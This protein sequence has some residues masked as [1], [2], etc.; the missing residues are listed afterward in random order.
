MTPTIRRETTSCENRTYIGLSIKV[1]WWEVPCMI[2]LFFPL[3]TTTVNRLA[4]SLHTFHYIH[5]SDNMKHLHIFLSS[6]H[7]LPYFDMMNE[8]LIMVPNTWHCGVWK[9]SGDDSYLLYPVILCNLCQFK[10]CQGLGAISLPSW[11]ISHF[12]HSSPSW[13]PEAYPNDLQLKIYIYQWLSTS[14]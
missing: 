1:C 13:K 7:L 3:P 8:I 2:W 6:Y 12:S 9:F 10:G 11:S 5:T 4:Y 14:L